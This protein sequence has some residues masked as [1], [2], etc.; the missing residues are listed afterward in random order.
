MTA[1]A[2]DTLADGGLEMRHGRQ[3]QFEGVAFR[4]QAVEHSAEDIEM[5][6]DLATAAAGQHQKHRRL[7]VATCLLLRVRPQRGQLLD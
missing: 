6:P 7:T 5:V 4:L 1:P 2:R 3:Y